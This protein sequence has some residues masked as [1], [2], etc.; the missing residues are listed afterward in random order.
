MPECQYINPL[1]GEKCGLETENWIVVGPVRLAVCEG[2]H[3]RDMT[4]G[5]RNRAQMQAGVRE[6]EEQKRHIA[7]SRAISTKGKEQP[8]EFP[9]RQPSLTWPPLEEA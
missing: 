7:Q 4:P 2:D 1:T 3:A 6:Y 5:G 9:S 8:T